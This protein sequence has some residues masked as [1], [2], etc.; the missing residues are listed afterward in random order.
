MEDLFCVLFMC[1]RPVIEDVIDTI[2]P[3]PNPLRGGQCWDLANPLRGLFVWHANPLRGLYAEW[4]PIALQAGLIAPLFGFV[5]M[6]L[7]L[8][9]SN[10]FI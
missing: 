2:E 1:C 5:S 6:L 4:D 9:K 8:F 7:L 10:S 3:Y